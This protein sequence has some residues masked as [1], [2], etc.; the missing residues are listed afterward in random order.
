MEAGTLV[1]WKVKE[2]DPVKHGDLVATVE[3]DK[4]A[5]DIEIFADGTI[6]KLLVPVGTKVPVGTV[7]ATFSDHAK[8]PAAVAPLPTQPVVAAAVSVPPPAVAAP[9]SLAVKP[10]AA[11]PAPRVE[12][13]QVKAPSA[14]TTPDPARVEAP[15]VQPEHRLRVSPLARKMAAEKHLSLEALSG[16]GPQ[17]AIVRADVERAVAEPQA[18]PKPTTATTPT[19]M[20][21]AIGAAVARAKKEIPHYY[22]TCDIDLGAALKWLQTLNAQR[23]VE[24]RIVPAALLLLAAA[25]AVKEVPELNGTFEQGELHA[26]LSVNLSVAI[27][28]RTPGLVAPAIRDAQALDVPA[29]MAALNDLVD[30]ARRGGLRSSE[31]AGGTLSV[32][33]LGDQ[34]VTSVLPIIFPPQVAMVGFGRVTER[35]WAVDGMLTVRPVVSVTLAADHRV[36]DGHRGGR[37]LRAMERLLN[38][39]EAM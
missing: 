3:T 31:M 26:S 20:R 2:G 1:E 32:T 28:L 30:R 29:M 27:H 36:S 25:K 39:P 24:Q 18:R 14:E 6:E 15:Q 21:S 37:Y 35:P 17:G 9:Q 23:S 16:T 8:V 33:N 22:L 4:G 19:A 34:G 7:L 10:Q 13:P 12:L 11:Q 38:N 5:I